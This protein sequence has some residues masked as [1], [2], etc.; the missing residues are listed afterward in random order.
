MTRDPLKNESP[1]SRTVEFG[2][3]L[4]TTESLRDCVPSSLALV[5]IL[6]EH[7]IEYKLIRDHIYVKDHSATFRGH[8]TPKYCF[9]WLDIT[10]YTQEQLK[11]CQPL[12]RGR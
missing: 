12:K 5:S 1:A 7:E 10:D 3:S 11:S 6:K 4:S 8:G 9:K 2:D